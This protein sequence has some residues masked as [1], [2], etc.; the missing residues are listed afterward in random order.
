MVITR[1]IEDW[2]QTCSLRD[3]W[4]ALLRLSSANQPTLSFE[5]ISEWWNQFGSLE[6]RR[7]RILTVEDS[8]QLIGIVPLLQRRIRKAHTL[9]VWTVELLASGEPEEHEICSDYLG[10]ISRPGFEEIVSEC[11]V[12]TL[13]KDNSIACDELALLNIDSS[14]TANQSLLKTLE[15]TGFA[16]SVTRRQICNYIELPDSWDDYLSMLSSSKRY[17]IRRSL[18]DFEAW[19]DGNAAFHQATDES[20]LNEGFEILKKLHAE[21]WKAENHAGVFA[22]ERFTAFHKTLTRELLAS[23]QL[24]LSWLTV[25]DEPI[26]ALY[27]IAWDGHIHFYQ[28]GRKVNL[29]NSIRPGIVIH[30]DAIQRA[31]ARGDRKY[32]FLAGTSRYKSDL[33]THQAELLDVRAYNPASIGGRT[34]QYAEKLGITLRGLKSRLRA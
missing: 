2:N 23:D 19:S 13:L 28:A 17:R 27:N 30:A 4:N 8:E 6:D 3:Q 32:D 31:I 26:A 11:T 29:P 22:S 7:L 10:V 1:T 33:A 25:R 21:R 5:W 34:S 12:E 16:P 18:R 20:S 15:Q 14:S 9:P 24:G